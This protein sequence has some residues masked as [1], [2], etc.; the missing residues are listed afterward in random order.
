MIGRCVYGQ[1]MVIDY[2][3]VHKGYVVR[4]R[5]DTAGQFKDFADVKL[6]MGASEDQVQAATKWLLAEI[7]PYEFCDI[8]VQPFEV[9]IA[10]T[11]FG[12]V[13]SDATNSVNLEPGPLA[14]FMAPW[15]GEYFT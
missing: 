9:I 10:G 4:F 11:T 6:D 12:L 5:F 8:H 2:S 15:D 3:G 13:C 14:T 1:F 7:E